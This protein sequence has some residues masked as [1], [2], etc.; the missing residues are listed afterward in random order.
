MPLARSTYDR[1]ESRP[2]RAPRSLNNLKEIDRA[3]G[4]PRRAAR[5]TWR[6]RAAARVAC[7][8]AREPQ[9]TMATN[10]AMEDLVT[11]FDNCLQ[12]WHEHGVFIVDDLVEPELL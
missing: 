11:D 5:A 2:R 10:V 4:G 8:G 9:P 6:A 12:V 3:G 7:R 1:D